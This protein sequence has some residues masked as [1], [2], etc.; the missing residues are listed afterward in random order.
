M[1]IINLERSVV[2][3]GVDMEFLRNSYCRKKLKK[4]LSYK[5]IE[6]ETELVSL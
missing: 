6:E 4:Y 1:F 3:T 5:N 2:V